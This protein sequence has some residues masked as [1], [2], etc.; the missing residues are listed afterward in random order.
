MKLSRWVKSGSTQGVWL[1]R[2]LPGVIV[3][4]FRGQWVVRAV[5][6][7]RPTEWSERVWGEEWETPTAVVVAVS[8]L[9][10]G[11]STRSAALLDL[12]ASLDGP[13]SSVGEML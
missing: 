2:A 8:C 9:R 10:K 11:Y 7:R 4:R 13:S 5:R 6:P 12:Q 1:V 3:E